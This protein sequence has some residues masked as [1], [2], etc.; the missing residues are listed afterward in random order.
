[1]FLLVVF[2]V[3]ANKKVRTVPNTGQN[4]AEVIFDFVEDL[5]LSTLGKKR[6]TCLCSIYFHYF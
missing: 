1:M 4:L 2:G 6:R 3:L 5:T